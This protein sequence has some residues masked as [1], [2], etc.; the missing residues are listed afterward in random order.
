MTLARTS[1]NASVFIVA[2]AIASGGC[3][4]SPTGRTAAD[5]SLLAPDESRAA[6]KVALARAEREQRCTTNPEERAHYD[7]VAHRDV[8]RKESV[9]ELHPDRCP[10]GVDDRRLA[11]CLSS[12][13]A[14]PCSTQLDDVA[15]V[16]ACGTEVLCRGDRTF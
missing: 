6:I 1:V 14:V 4:R 2:L 13:A 5:G 15:R 7:V 10:A 16:E 3:Y 9:R 11:T 8:Y 12:I